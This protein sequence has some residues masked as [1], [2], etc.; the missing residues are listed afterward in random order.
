[1]IYFDNAATTWPKAPGVAGAM[2]R[3][4]R[5]VGANPGRAAHRQ[6]LESGRIVYGA[7]GAVCELFHAPDPLRL[8]WCK[9][10]PRRSTSRCAA[11]FVRAT[12]RHQLALEPNPHAASPEYS[13]TSPAD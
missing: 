7:R 6:A 12:T 5:E 11:C 4:I 3:F 8:V 9:T 13:G 1:M 2:T 10:S